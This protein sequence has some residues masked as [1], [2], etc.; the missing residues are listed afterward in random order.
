MVLSPTIG[1]LLLSTC[2]STTLRILNVFPDRLST[3]IVSGLYFQYGIPNSGQ[4]P[5]MEQKTSSLPFSPT[6]ISFFWLLSVSFFSF[7]FLLVPFLYFLFSSLN[8]HCSSDFCCSSSYHCAT[9]HHIPSLFL[10]HLVET[11]FIGIKP[12]NYTFVSVIK[13]N[14]NNNITL[15]LNFFCQTANVLSL[16][17]LMLNIA[18]PNVLAVPRLV[19]KTYFRFFLK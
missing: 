18:M 15:L 16:V 14:I 8:L 10:S 19:K 9:L 17:S 4:G 2:H 12:K 7:V 13:I 11:Y 5:P 1:L 3:I 6:S